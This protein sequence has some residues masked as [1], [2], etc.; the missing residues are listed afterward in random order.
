MNTFV[1]YVRRFIYYSLQIVQTPIVVVK[2][3]NKKIKYFE[4][5]YCKTGLK[6][7]EGF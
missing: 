6:N 5:K 4:E 3:E 7:D 1:N 2:Q